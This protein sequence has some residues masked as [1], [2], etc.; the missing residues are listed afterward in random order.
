MCDEFLFAIAAVAIVG[1]VGAIFWEA[2]QSLPN[3][4][5]CDDSICD[6]AECPFCDAPKLSETKTD[7]PV[8]YKR[9]HLGEFEI[10]GEG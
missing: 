1:V 8:I 2:A 7:G 9:Q 4:D 6:P 3:C 10:G 5:V